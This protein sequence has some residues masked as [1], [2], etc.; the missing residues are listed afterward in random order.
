MY[1]HVGVMEVVVE[2]AL[3]HVLQH[4]DG[5]GGGGTHPQEQHHPGVSQFPKQVHLGNNETVKSLIQ[6]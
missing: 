4:H 1:L 5:E 6:Q 2:T 3:S